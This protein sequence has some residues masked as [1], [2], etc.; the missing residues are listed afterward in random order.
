MEYYLYRTEIGYIPII[1]E[2][3][4]PPFYLYT[5]LTFIPK[6][7][8]TSGVINYIIDNYVNGE[9]EYMCIFHRGSYN[10]DDQFFNGLKRELVYSY[11]IK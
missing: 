2:T 10:S 4:P 5:E 1:R 3:C 6:K 8:L 11:V 9:G 7:R